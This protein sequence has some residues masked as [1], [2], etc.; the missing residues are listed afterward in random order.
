MGRPTFLKG[1]STVWI[2]CNGVLMWRRVYDCLDYLPFLTRCNL[3]HFWH[4][5]KIIPLLLAPARHT[6][7]A[8]GLQ[9]RKFWKLGKMFRFQLSSWLYEIRQ[10]NVVAVNKDKHGEL[11][12]CVYSV[13]TAHPACYGYKGHELA[14]IFNCAKWL[15]YYFLAIL[16]MEDCQVLTIYLIIF[17]IYNNKIIIIIIK[18]LYSVSL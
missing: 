16:F 18:D 1:R 8:E 3:F 12:V 10:I 4:Q 13:F 11:E 15:Q 14:F 5:G 7:V 2:V 6:A 9:K 17:L